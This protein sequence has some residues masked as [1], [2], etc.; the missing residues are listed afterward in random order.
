M[1]KQFM[2][3]TDPLILFTLVLIVPRFNGPFKLHPPEET[4]DL[5]VIAFVALIVFDDAID[6]LVILAHVNEPELLILPF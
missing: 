1:L 2:F 5:P 4:N 6:P 3:K